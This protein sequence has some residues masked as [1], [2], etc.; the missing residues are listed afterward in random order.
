MRTGNHHI[1]LS[2][3]IFMDPEFCIFFVLYF[4]LFCFI[5]QCFKWQCDPVLGSNYLRL[6]IGNFGTSELHKIWWKR[7]KR[8]HISNVIFLVSFWRWICLVL[9]ISD[10]YH[11]VCKL[12]QF[13]T[14]LYKT[15]NWYLQALRF[16]TKCN[17]MIYQL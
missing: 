16:R 11:S 2:F 12:M 10:L 13:W 5:F 14:I 6:E 17:V 3:G 4:Y 7:M 15:V 8:Y 9:H 1:C